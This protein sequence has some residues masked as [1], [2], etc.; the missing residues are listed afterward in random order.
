MASGLLRYEIAPDSLLK[1]SLLFLLVLFESGRPKV[2]A[3]WVFEFC[4]SNTE[5]FFPNVRFN[6]LCI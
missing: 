6:S 3:T 4:H 2:G 1:N 5:C